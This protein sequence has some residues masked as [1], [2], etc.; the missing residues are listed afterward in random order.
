MKTRLYL[1]DRRTPEGKPAP[2]KIALSHRGECVYFSTDISVESRYWDK[3]GGDCCV[4]GH[5]ESRIINNILRRRLL[6]IE[7]ALLHVQSEGMSMRARCRDLRDAVLAQIQPQEEKE[8]K[9]VLL[10]EQY[11]KVMATKKAH[12]TRSNYHSGKTAL[13]RYLGPKASRITLEDIDKRWLERYSTWL[14]EQGLAP[15]SIVCRLQVLRAVFNAALDDELTTNYPFRKFKFHGEQTIKRNLPLEQLR[16]LWRAE[17]VTP[18]EEQ[19]LDLFKLT[20]YLIGINYADLFKLKTSN[21]VNGRLEY[22]RSKTGKLYSIKLYPEALAI[23]DKYRGPGDNLLSLN[24]QYT[25]CCNSL[26]CTNKMLKAVAVRAGLECAGNITTY[27]AR[28][29]WATL[30]ANIDTPIEVISAALGHSYGSSTTAVYIDFNMEKV[31]RA[32]R[33]LIDLVTSQNTTKL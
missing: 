17:A 10:M 15:N 13:L 20:F 29:S 6:E 1:D 23:I 9:R 30:A 25:M 28:H 26:M 32:N 19:A 27:W 2:V 11:D 33:R 8:D 14:S 22:R 21:V 5:P 16:Q 18:K 3:N 31:D 7:T 12:A 4:V 24:N